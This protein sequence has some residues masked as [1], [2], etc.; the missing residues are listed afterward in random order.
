MIFD[1]HAH[2]MDEHMPGA[3]FWEGL[4]KTVSV[5]SGKPAD[6]IATAMKTVWDRTGQ[7]LISQMDLAGVDKCMIMP[8]DWGLHPAFQNAMN[9]W[10]QHL[11]HRALVDKYPD[12]IVLFACIDPRRIDA[13]TMLDDAINHLGCVGLKI[14][15]AAGFYPNDDLAY[16]LYER[17]EEYK[18]PV[19][20]HTG[21]EPNPLYSKY[22]QPIYMDQ[23]A[24]DFPEL[25]II[26]AHAGF[27]AWVNEAIAVA[28]SSSNVYLDI[29]GWQLMAKH[30]PNDFY[31]HFNRMLSIVGST[32]I[33]WGS[34]YPALELVM[35]E[36]E[37][38]NFIND[39]YLHGV[40]MSLLDLQ[41]ITGN[42]AMKIISN[43]VNEV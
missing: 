15:P 29:S 43:N 5:R 11:A 40:N 19:M 27:E 2:L 10:D 18:I 25:K 42:N 38:L 36:N 32:R 7:K 17:C 9:I 1:F 34:D 20:V 23:V 22:C 31:S 4:F 37:W 39:S 6:Q 13:I 24:V 21:P 14:H 12:R 30:R 8:I 16:K 28:A 3:S 33:L 26:L 35:Q 41:N